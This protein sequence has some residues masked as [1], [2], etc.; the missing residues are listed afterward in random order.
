M[1]LPYYLTCGCNKVIRLQKQGLIGQ[2]RIYFYA[3]L[4]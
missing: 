2:L 1:F 4:D 3:V